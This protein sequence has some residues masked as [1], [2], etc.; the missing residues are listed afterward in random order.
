MRRFNSVVSVLLVLGLLALSC[1]DSQRGRVPE[2]QGRI[3][4]ETTVASPGSAVAV[5]PI[6]GV[7]GFVRDTVPDAAV[8]RSLGARVTVLWL[9]PRA[10]SRFDVNYAIQFVNGIERQTGGLDIYVHLMPNARSEARGESGTGDPELPGGPELP[11]SGAGFTV[12]GDM[13]A[14]LASVEELVTALKGK[15]TYYSIG[16]EVSGFSWKGTPED[17]GMFL[18]QTSQAIKSVDPDAKILDS[19]MAGLSYA[20]T[21]PDSLYREGKTADAIDFLKRY[22]RNHAGGFS[23]FLPVDDE[24][25]LKS[26]LTHAIAQKTIAMSDARFKEY[27]PYYDIFQLHDYQGWQTMEEVYDWVYEKMRA[28]NCVKPIQAWEIGYGLDKNLPYD[29]NEHARSVTKILTISAAKGAQTIIYFPLSEK[30]TY[31]RG[32]LEPDGT[33]GAPAKAYQVTVER[34][35][36][37]MNAERLNLG[38]GVWA[39]KF[40]NSDK[41]VYVVWSADSKTVR[42]PIAAS[43]VTLTD[44]SGSTATASPYAVPVEVDPVFVEAS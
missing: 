22:T 41:E 6:F 9:Y 10:G 18:S 43:Q 33:I 42:L 11:E 34:L 3:P 5:Q 27:C 26:M 4:E 19:G 28:N 1:A 23:Q 32:L 16:N 2:R 25:Q 13:A 35:A 8:I 36:G 14:Y 29:V 37:V 38:E 15:V 17:Y 12:P 7:A 30:G 31:A 20:F 40:Q 44:K 39:Y 24:E 21:I